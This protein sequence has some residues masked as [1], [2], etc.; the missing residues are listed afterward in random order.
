MIRHLLTP[1]WK[2]KG[3]N[4]LLSLEIALAFAV[5]FGI[6]AAGLRYWQLY[7]QPVG[8]AWRDAWAVQLLMPESGGHDAKFDPAVYAQLQGA[9]ERLPEVEKSA[10]TAYSPYENS[11]W[12]SDYWL[13]GSNRKYGTN[14]MKVSDGF[15]D[16]MGV[17]VI[18]GRAFSVADDGA[19][20]QPV[21]V[22]RSSAGRG[23]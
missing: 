14:L 15:F 3:R 23:S 12:N 17:K 20:R 19:A 2:R 9:V 13:P 16:T 11:E 22:S 4:L 1:R 7:H 8:F 5:V 18:E 10:L 6:A 21:L